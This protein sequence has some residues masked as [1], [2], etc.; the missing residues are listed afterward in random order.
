MATTSYVL[1]GT[2]IAT[3]DDFY[4]EIGEVVAGPGG[5]FGTNLDALSDC[6]SGGFGTPD[7][8]RDSFEFVWRDSERS[9][10]EMSYGDTVVQLTQRL[11]R[12]HPQNRPSV[13]SQLR[14]ATEGRG[15]TTFDWILGI[16]QHQGVALRLE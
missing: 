4:R 5:Y 14:A 3:L 2:R 1:D 12:C 15:S 6:L 10:A 8:P 11:E 9:R 13:E 16:F 7:G